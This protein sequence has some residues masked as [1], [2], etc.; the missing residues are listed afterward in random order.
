LVT[1]L[2]NNKCKLFSGRDTFEFFMPMMKSI[3]D[4]TFTPDMFKQMFNTSVYKEMMDKMFGMQPDWMKNM[5]ENP[6]MTSMKDNMNNMMNSNKT[7]FDNM[8]GMITN[9][10]PNMN[11]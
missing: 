6:A 10:M 1:G 7:M 3:Q 5:M 11:D 2:L 4:K 8:K 9:N